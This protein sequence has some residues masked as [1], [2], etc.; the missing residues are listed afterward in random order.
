[1]SRGRLTRIAIMIAV[2]ASVG[3]CE[4]FSTMSDPAAIQPHEREPLA[5][6]EGSIPLGGLPAY[7]LA[8]ADTILPSNPVAADSA[9]MAR[10]AAAY[11]T[12]CYVCHGANG[13]GNGPISELFPAIPSLVTPQ[14]A[15]YTDAYVFTVI[16]QGRGLMP[17]Y[18]RIPRRDRWGLVHYVKRRLAAE[19]APADTAS[20]DTAPADTTAGG[21]S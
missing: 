3:A 2:A 11:E 5:P 19:A 13:L 16:S 17:E 10:G 15:G 4:W 9:G 14:V 12:F 6:P 18:G 21:G 1:M 7:D 20:P 8:S